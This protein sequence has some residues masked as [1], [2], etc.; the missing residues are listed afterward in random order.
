MKQI[1]FWG[2]DTATTLAHW[3]PWQDAESVGTS[4]AGTVLFI[5]WTDGIKEVRPIA[6][7]RFQHRDKPAP[8][9]LYLKFGEI[10]GLFGFDFTLKTK[11]YNPDV[12]DTLMHFSHICKFGAS[13]RHE[14]CEC[15]CG[16]VRDDLDAWRPK[17]EGQRSDLLIVD[18]PPR[19]V[20]DLKDSDLRVE[21][22]R[23]GTESVVKITH[24]PTGVAVSTSTPGAT[25]FANVAEARRSLVEQLNE[26]RRAEPVGSSVPGGIDMDRV[27]PDAHDPSVPNTRSDPSGAS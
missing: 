13:E 8:L 23:S 22:F 26:L 2:V 16:H 5:T 18:D 27:A 9:D 19:T 6:G 15:R 12:W 11:T 25:E 14:R 10:P 7:L 17:I 3:G 4:T 21:V 20:S 1:R 24:I